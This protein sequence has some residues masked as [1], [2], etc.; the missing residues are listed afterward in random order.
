MWHE[1]PKVYVP[2]VSSR[3]DAVVRLIHSPPETKQQ[4]WLGRGVRAH[5]CPALH[6]RRRLHTGDAQN[7][8]SEIHKTYQTLQFG[9]RPVSGRR[10]VFELRGDIYD[11]RHT[12]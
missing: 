6:V 4:A 12:E 3:A 10:E 7:R 1:L 8:R 2:S 5:E 9:A 11:Q